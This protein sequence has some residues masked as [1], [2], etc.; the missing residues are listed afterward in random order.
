MF[1]YPTAETL[2]IIWAFNGETPLHP[3]PHFDVDERELVVDAFRN[4]VTMPIDGTL[5]FLNSF[6]LQHFRVVHHMPIEVDS[7]T[8]CAKRTTH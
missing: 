6:D 8:V 2:G 3:A 4:P 7:S 1:D 5:V